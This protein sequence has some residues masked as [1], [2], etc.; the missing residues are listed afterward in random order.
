MVLLACV[1]QTARNAAQRSL[2]AEAGA[3]GATLVRFLYGLP[4]ALLVVALL[5][6][7]PGSPPPRLSRFGAAYFGWLALGAVSQIMA[8][9]CLLMAMKARNFIVGVVLAKTEVLQVAVF[10]AVALHEWPAPAAAGAMLLASAGVVLVSLPARP[11]ASA[12]PATGFDL[13]SAGWGLGAG[14]G[15]ALSAVG[16]RGAAL[17]VAE[18]PPWLAGAWGVLWAQ[19]LQSLLL[20]GWLLATAPA[21]LGVITRAWRPSMLAGLAGALASIGWFTAFA[22]RP[23]AE[24]RTLS[25][26]EVLLS[27]AVSRRLLREQL[28]PREALGLV[29]VTAGVLLICA[30]ALG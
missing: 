14:A 9:A 20:G 28:A 4:V 24:V 5:Q 17:Q 21:V 27:Y 30:L 2:T 16:F 29:L 7:L 1:A 13:R 8:T 15:F 18:L 22:M 10:A 12:G 19:A 23:A 3:L 6:Q 26:I 11:E 25:L